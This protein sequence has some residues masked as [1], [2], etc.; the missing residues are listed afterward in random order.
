M[1]LTSENGGGTGMVM[2]V[3]PMAGGAG[4]YP[5]YGGNNNDGFG[6]DGW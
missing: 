5:A 3:A 6:G 1:S 4:Y 2:H